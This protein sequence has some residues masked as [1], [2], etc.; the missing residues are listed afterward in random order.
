VRLKGH[1]RPKAVRVPKK[2]N[3]QGHQGH[4]ESGGVSR[5]WLS[6]VADQVIQALRAE[7]AKG[8]RDAFMVS[9]VSL[10][11][12]VVNVLFDACGVSEA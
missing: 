10:V 3:H 4:Q 2:F 1:F 9:L 5:G 12:L 6:R 7:A 11:S 8:Q